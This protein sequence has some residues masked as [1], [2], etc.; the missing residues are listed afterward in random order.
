MLDAP[1]SLLGLYSHSVNG[2]AASSQFDAG[3]SLTRIVEPGQIELVAVAAWALATGPNNA[4]MASFFFDSVAP[5]NFLQGST[6][7]QESDMN[8]DESYIAGIP[9]TEIRVLF[10]EAAVRAGVIRP[11]DPLDEMQVDFAIEIVTL[12]AR[13]AD[14]YPNPDRI[15]DTVGDV[16]RG[17]LFELGPSPPGCR[18]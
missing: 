2:K 11:G 10:A 3:R 7:A 16:I 1:G 5:S 17:Q 12:C 4:S 8:L 15:H 13:L 9:A 6:T 14:R 18:D